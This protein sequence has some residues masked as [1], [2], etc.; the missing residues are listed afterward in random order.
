MK[1]L[2]EL[3]NRI[4]SELSQGITE[5]CQKTD[6]VRKI[7]LEECEKDKNFLTYLKACEKGRNSDK[8]LELLLGMI[9]I[10]AVFSF[11]LTVIRELLLD[12]LRFTL[13]CTA[14][15]VGGISCLIVLIS[16]LVYVIKF[17]KEQFCSCY[18]YIFAVAEELEKEEV[19][20]HETY[21]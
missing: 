10:V 12:P 5:G 19:K 17:F 2:K 21:N 4:K 3:N 7:V 14:A 13:Y 16:A 9:G 15:T 20:K 18:H 8:A 1:G 11:A 6:V